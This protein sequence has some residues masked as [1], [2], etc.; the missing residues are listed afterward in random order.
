MIIDE[1]TQIIGRFHKQASSRGLNIYNPLFQEK[2]INAVY[3]LF[4]DPDPKVLMTGYRALKL[5][6]AITAGFESDP[7]LPGLVDDLDEVAKFIGRIGYISNVKGKVV[8]HAQGGQGML[9]TIKHI[10][11]PAHKKN[12]YCRSWQCCKSTPF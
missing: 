8:G 6:G 4:Y 10:V 1:N 9:R 7:M 3:L 5:S 12:Y 2:G 11:D